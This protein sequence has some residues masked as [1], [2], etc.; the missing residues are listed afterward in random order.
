[1]QKLRPGAFRLDLS[2]FVTNVWRADLPEDQ[3]FD[4]CL[5]PSFWMHVVEKVIVDKASPRGI[6]DELVVFKRD[7]MAKRRYMISGIGDGFMRLVEIERASVAS[8]LDLRP[9][10]PLQTRWNVGKR[11]HEVVRE[12]A[13]GS[14]TVMAG[15]FQSKGEAV[16]WINDH[17]QKM[18][19]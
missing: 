14:V 4:D 18:A 11:G 8:P 9:D 6:G 2:G 19:A 12:D 13:P 7:A 16:D 3:N 5:N 17:L 10:S 15:P 1:M